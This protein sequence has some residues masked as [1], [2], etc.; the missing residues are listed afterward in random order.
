MSK[1]FVIFDDGHD[2]QI[3]DIRMHKEAIFFK[4]QS[5]Q[6]KY[7]HDDTSAGS[8]L[9]QHA[10]YKFVSDIIDGGKWLR[11]LEV[12]NIMIRSDIYD[13]YNQ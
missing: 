10:F 12:D 4:C 3:F 11:T 1:G 5:G 13:K 6:Y 8:I 7:V 9:S 2:E